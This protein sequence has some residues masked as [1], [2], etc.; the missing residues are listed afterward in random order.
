MSMQVKIFGT[1][2]S[3]PVASHECVKYGGNTT[4]LR[5]LSD[6]IPADTALVID[7]GSGYVPM[8][9][10]LMKDGT[11]KNVVV[12]FTH[13]HHD[14]TQGLPLAPTTFIPNYRMRLIGPTDQGIGPKEMLENIMRP[15]F[16]P[17]S[18]K[19]VSHRFHCDG[20]DIPE[21]K[22]ILI[23]PRGGVKIL[24]VNEFERLKG[25]DGR[26][27]FGDGSK[28]L[29]IECLIIRMVKSDHPECTISYRF[30]EMT[31][32]RVFTFLTD[33]EN[34][35]GIPQSLRQH[36]KGSHLLIADSQ[37]N[38]ETYDARTAGYGHGTPD[39]VIRL[40]AECGISHVGLTHHD[41]GSTDRKIDL[42][43]E[44]ARASAHVRSDMRIFACSDYQ[45]VEV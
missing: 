35:D 9:S 8:A 7:A 43:L 12:L 34:Q 32:G 27:P 23:H 25:K 26:V 10:E 44:E 18:H 4:C 37:Y 17:V 13:Y 21:T 42:I 5:I 6:L 38:R 20:L 1:R 28:N 41:P 19:K 30:E 16:F 39:Y 22:V 40:A 33:H 24:D 15:P 29:I 11:I 31:T 2:G 3:I 45:L 14:H 36:L